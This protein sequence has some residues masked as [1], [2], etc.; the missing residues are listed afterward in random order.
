MTPPTFTKN[1]DA[2]TH[3]FGPFERKTL[4]D[5]GCGRGRLLRALGKRGAV[6][7]GVDP[8]PD[9]LAKAAE[10]APDATLHQSGGEALPFEDNSF[11]GAVIL[12]A[13]HHVPA[14]L[15]R[16]ALAEGM[17]VTRPGGTF[18][19]IEPLA[20]GGYQEVFAPLDDETEIRA[21]ALAALDAF[22]AETGARVT[23]R[24][25]YET[26]LRE[27][28]V[29]AMLAAGVAIDPARAAKVDAVRKEIET[30]FSHHARETAD[31]YLLDQP[32]IAVALQK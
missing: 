14:A 21:V 7:T 27:E 3:I 1:M 8:N 29:G 28:G 19:I 31:G 10:L 26:L 23:L 15:M 32:M 13:L 24:T 5:I 6:M 12:N 2:L 20:R 18:L 17:R 16:P 22:I 9:L 25:E 11:D 4:L 30:L